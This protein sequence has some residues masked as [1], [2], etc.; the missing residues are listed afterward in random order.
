LRGSETLVIPTEFPVVARAEVAS[1]IESMKGK[2]K[3]REM[4]G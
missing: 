1:N 3:H 2:A 4:N